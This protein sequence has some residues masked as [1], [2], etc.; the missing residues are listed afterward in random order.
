MI[1]A[2]DV[3]YSSTIVPPVHI[4]LLVVCVMHLLID[5]TLH[6]PLPTTRQQLVE[7]RLIPLILTCTSAAPQLNQA[8]WA[9]ESEFACLVLH[10]RIY[11]V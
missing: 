6:A 8:G 1:A 10:C 7:A 9:C 3:L 2:N 4:S 5:R 11:S